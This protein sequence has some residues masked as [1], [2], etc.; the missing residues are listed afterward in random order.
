MCV[1]V[2]PC[3]LANMSRRKCLTCFICVGKSNTLELCVHAYM[4]AGMCNVC[5]YASLHMFVCLYVCLHVCMHVC[6]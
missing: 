5:T 1:D 2:V 3:Y 6:M 4:H